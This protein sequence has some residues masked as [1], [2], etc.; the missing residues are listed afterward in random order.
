MVFWWGKVKLW[1]CLARSE[2][3]AFVFG[4]LGSLGLDLLSSLRSVLVV[5][6]LGRDGVFGFGGFAG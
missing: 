2:G 5:A 4:G 3:V 6:G 1:A